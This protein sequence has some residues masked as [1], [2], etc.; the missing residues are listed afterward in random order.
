M[1]AMIQ[2][3]P[4]ELDRAANALN[5]TKEMLLS[6]AKGLRMTMS[7][8]P[9]FRGQAADRFRQEM[10]K[11]ARSTQQQAEEVGRQAESLRRLAR[12]L[13]AVRMR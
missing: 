5:R 4:D 7:Y 10:D 13:R 3:D 1:S 8:L 11:L 9:R 6:S 12:E 2:A